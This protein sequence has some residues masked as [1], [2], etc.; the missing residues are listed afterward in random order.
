MA[1]DLMPLNAFF[2]TDVRFFDLMVIVFK[3][4]QPLNASA[5]MEVTWL[6]M[7]TVFSFLLFLNAPFA[8]EVTLN[9]MP[10]I[11]TVLGT[12]KEFLELLAA[13]NATVP[14]V[15]PDLVTL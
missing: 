13:A 2:P 12:T 3:F 5:P 11:S 4:L 1:L 8:I 7:V 14:F 9:V 6:L 15:L 10:W